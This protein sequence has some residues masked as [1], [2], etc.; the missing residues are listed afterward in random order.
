MSIA[1]NHPNIDNKFGR[2]CKDGVNQVR[3]KR[4]G[5]KNKE[6]FYERFLHI[7]YSFIHFSISG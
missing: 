2:P 1:A 4:P 6:Y 5:N 3:G 7:Y